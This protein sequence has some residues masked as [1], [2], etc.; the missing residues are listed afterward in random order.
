MKV[1]VDIRG[2]DGVLATLRALPRE[3]SAKRGGPVAAAARTG[4]QPMKR[5]H[6]ANLSAATA[7]ATSENRRLS[8]GFLAKNVVISRGKAPT[9]GK[10]ERYLLRVRRK[11]YPDRK[12]KP[13]TTLAAAQLLEYGSSQQP[14][15]PWIR[16]SFLSRAREVIDTT[17]ADLVRRLDKIVARLAR[18]NAAKA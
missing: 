1:D 18:Q 14:A 15:E 2:I 5:Q 4:L 3:V 10:G 8:T 11:T 7:N 9:S 13:V 6:L 17:S 12:G 16:P